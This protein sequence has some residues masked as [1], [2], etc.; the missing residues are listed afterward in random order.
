RRQRD[1]TRN[2]PLASCGRHGCVPRRGRRGA[3]GSRIP[4]AGV[5]VLRARDGGRSFLS[6]RGGERPRTAAESS[7]RVGCGCEPA[8]RAGDAVMDGTLGDLDARYDATLAAEL[9]RA[10]T[11]ALPPDFPRP[12]LPPPLRESI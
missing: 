4:R 11:R 7:W 12:W 10:G 1:R 9:A 5:P 3:E 6:A 8:P 2:A